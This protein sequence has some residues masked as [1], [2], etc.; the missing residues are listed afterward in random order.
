MKHISPLNFFILSDGFSM[1]ELMVVV[2]IIGVLV[3]IAAPNFSRYQSKTRQSEAKVALAA[4]YAG[5][6]S[7]KTEYSSYVSSLDAIG[8]APEGA[9]RYYNVGFNATHG[10]TIS[11]YNGQLVNGFWTESLNP[12]TCVTELTEADLPANLTGNAQSFIVG[13]VGCIREGAENSDQWNM[14][15]LKELVNNNI[16]L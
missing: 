8:Y 11:G 10:S 1:I 2:G 6:K 3:A 7:F 9:R 12:F 5:E 4:I 14:N 15:D 13:A 16:Q